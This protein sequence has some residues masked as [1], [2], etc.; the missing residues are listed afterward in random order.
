[1]KA[2]LFALALAFTPPATQDNP[3]PMR[4]DISHVFLSLDADLAGF[5]GQEKGW[6]NWNRRFDH[7]ASLFFQGQLLDA[8]DGMAALRAEV[9]GLSGEDAVA[10]RVASS[11]R[12]VLEDPLAR[13]TKLRV[14]GLWPVAGAA[15]KTIS[16]K[17]DLG[18]EFASIAILLECDEDGRAG[19]VTLDLP[20]LPDVSPEARVTIMSPDGSRCS[21]VAWT[22]SDETWGERRERLLAIVAEVEDP[23]LQP[24]LREFRERCEWVVADPDAR[25]SLHA[26]TSPRA[27]WDALESE[28]FELVSG[29]DPYRNELVAGY[30][31]L[32]RSI[33]VESREVY[34]VQRIAPVQSAD[35]LR[36]LLIAL[37]GAGGDEA[38][39]ARAAGGGMLIDLSREHGFHL[40]CPNTYQMLYDMPAFDAI[41]KDALERY[42]VDP[43]R[44]YVMG[45]SLGGINTSAIVNLR[46]ERVTA[47]CCIAG[48]RRLK[49]EVP[50]LVQ[51]AELDTIF[52]IV[53]LRRDAKKARDDGFPLTL[54]EHR[55]T[56]HVLILGP[57][58]RRAVEFFG[59]VTD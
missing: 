17:V 45:H 34:T 9:L 19:S 49:V 25:R 1:M 46:A 57:A 11:L 4:R 36:P 40:I 10:F 53:D 31:L 54:E 37:H 35:D 28:A 56:G 43:E 41:L 15:G 21:T 18:P 44:V 7:I 5:T 22:P 42:P 58:V 8:S 50:V 6:R 29:R 27:Y 59:L 3:K 52:D 13:E 23:K 47:G 30:R 38:F 55:D 51:A 12:P 16:F 14:E 39:F 20:V 26:L 24:S 2:L 33:A 32:W 48:G